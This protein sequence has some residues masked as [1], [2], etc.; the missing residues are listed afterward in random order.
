M[1]QAITLL[2]AARDLAIIG[3]LHPSAA[4]AA[5]FFAGGYVLGASKNKT[6]FAELGRGLISGVAAWGIVALT[7]LLITGA[8]A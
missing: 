7:Q 3:L 2:V 5:G 6:A 1:D 4:V 8:S